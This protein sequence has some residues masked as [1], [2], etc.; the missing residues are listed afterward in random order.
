[1]GLDTYIYNHKLNDGD[2]FKHD[3]EVAYWRKCWNLHRWFADY[4]GLDATNDNL[5]Q[6]EVTR[7]CLLD[8]RDA[9]KHNEIEPF[10]W[11]EDRKTTQ[12]LIKEML[13]ETNWATETL[14]WESWY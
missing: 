10:A 2:D 1:M 3:R 9:I 14:Y 5:N 13:Q 7:E 12:H 8:L 6:Q 4:F 11:D